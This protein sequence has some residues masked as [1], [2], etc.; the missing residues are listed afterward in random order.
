VSRSRRSFLGL[1]AKA[2]AAAACAAV[3]PVPQ[4]GDGGPAWVLDAA[5]YRMT[6]VSFA[7]DAGKRFSGGFLTI[8]SA[9]GEVL[10][11]GPAD[12]GEI[13]FDAPINAEDIGYLQRD[14]CSDESIEV[15]FTCWSTND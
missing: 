13:V 5:S 11:S 9:A 12:A 7:V 10:W 3:F 1:L 4:L 15:D 8:M 14:A 6:G 2:G